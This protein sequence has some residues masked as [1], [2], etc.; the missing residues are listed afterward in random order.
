MIGA[1]VLHADANG[2]FMLIRPDGVTSRFDGDG[3]QS[4]SA[5]CGYHDS[6]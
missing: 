4:C 2:L 5:F 3:S 6:A 1:G